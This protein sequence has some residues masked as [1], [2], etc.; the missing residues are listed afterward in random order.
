VPEEAHLRGSVLFFTVFRTLAKRFFRFIIVFHFVHGHSEGGRLGVSMSSVHAPVVLISTVIVHGVHH[1]GSLANIVD[2]V[3][4]IPI[5]GG[6]P[7]SCHPFN[8]NRLIL[9]HIVDVKDFLA[10]G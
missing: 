6:A 10:E 2:K 8:N 4:L 3:L 5:G 7:V 9:Y 1:A